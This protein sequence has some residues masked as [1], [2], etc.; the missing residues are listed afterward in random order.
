MHVR[1]Y[2]VTPTRTL[3]QM[4]NVTQEDITNIS[5]NGT[6]IDENTEHT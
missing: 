5:T 6:K 1:N 2:S 3:D 4:C